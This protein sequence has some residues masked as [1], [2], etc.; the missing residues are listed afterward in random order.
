MEFHRKY[1]GLL[2]LVILLFGLTYEVGHVLHQLDHARHSDKQDH[3]SL[4]KCLVFHAGKLV[5]TSVL[6]N[7]EVA[8]VTFV[9]ELDL[10]QYVENIACRLPGTRAPPIFS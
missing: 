3:E 5:E 4:C 1:M 10:H 2:V 9:T 6:L 7:H 8:F